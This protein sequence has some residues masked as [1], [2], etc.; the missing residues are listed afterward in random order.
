MTHHSDTE[1][2]ART[3]QGDAAAFGTLVERYK[4]AVYGVCVSV[5]HDFDLAQDLAQEAF[6]KAFQ[7]LYRLAL[8]ARFGHWLRIIAVNE[9]RLYLRQARSALVPVHT[10]YDQAPLCQAHLLPMEQQQELRQQQ[11]YQDRLGVAALQALG[12]L[13]EKNRQAITL[14]YLG[15]HSLKEVGAFLGTSSA[16]VKMRLHRAR[17]QLQKEALNMVERT[18]TQ[19][20]L[21]PEF[22]D[23]VQMATLTIFFSDITGFADIA[24]QLSSEDT[25]ALLYEYMSDMTQI[26]LDSAG[27]LDKY[28]W[29]AIMA[30]WGAPARSEDHAVQG[31]LA[32][33]DMQAR[34]RELGAKWHQEGR[35]QL[36]VKCGLHTGTVLVGEMGSRQ[37]QTYTVLGNAVHIASRLEGANARF[38]TS[39]LVSRETYQHAQ[40]AIEARIVGQVKVR[41]FPEPVTVYEVLAHKGGLDTRKAQAIAPYLEGF[42][43]YQARQWERA[44]PA[45]NAALQLD[46]S[47][48]P[49]R[50]YKDRCE[51]LL[52]APPELLVL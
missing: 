17:Q 15:G 9:C 6:I 22:A 20:Q 34:L 46:P 8:P 38:G 27:T 32:A 37:R 43:Y 23:R 45:F 49:S 48:G 39:I 13:S 42:E 51:A 47:D 14:Y 26:I 21:G 4:Q 33:L 50:F 36:R 12:A 35:P 19:R 16:A 29:D 7:H 3:L 28:E 5:V 11:D 1:L 25:L 10:F 30:F 52:A 31:C 44:L 18:L 2:V 41:P 24:T 40:S